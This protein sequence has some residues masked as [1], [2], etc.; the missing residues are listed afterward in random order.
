MGG[1]RS[2]RPAEKGCSRHRSC[3]GQDADRALRDKD[4]YETSPRSTGG[5]TNHRH[6]A[7]QD[8]CPRQREDAEIKLYNDNVTIFDQIASGNAT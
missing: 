4:K 6:P 3:R 2:A 5:H 1:S 7:H 8:A